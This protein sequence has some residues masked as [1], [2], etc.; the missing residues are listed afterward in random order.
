MQAEQI[1]EYGA[2]LASQS[3][4]PP[5]PQGTEVFNDYRWV[6]GGGGRS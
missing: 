3:L 5:V 4:A 2:P 1:I 6:E